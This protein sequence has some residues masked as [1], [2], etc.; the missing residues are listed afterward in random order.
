MPSIK[1][2]SVCDFNLIERLIFSENSFSSSKI[3]LL[4]IFF[5]DINLAGISPRFKDSSFKN[6]SII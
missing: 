2:S 5:E 3:I 6:S 1:L 4:S